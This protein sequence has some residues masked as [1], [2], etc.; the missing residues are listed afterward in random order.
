[1]ARF[2]VRRLIQAIPTLIGISIIAFAIMTLAPGGPTTALASDPNLTVQQREAIAIALGARDPIPTQYMRWLIGDAPIEWFGT[3]IWAGREVPT[4]DRLGNE[5][6]STS[7]TREGIL[8]GDW[9]TSITSKKPVLDVLGERIPATLELGIISLLVGTIVGIPIGVLSAVY[10][11]GLFDQVSRVG[12]VIVSAIPVFWLGLILLLI[13]GSW[14]GWFPMGNRFPLSFSGDYSFADRLRH[15]FLP[16][17]TL[18][19]F[20]IAT[21]SRYTR[22]SVLDVLGQDYIRTASAK[23][24]TGRTVWF[25]HGLRNALIP[26][27]TLL[28]PSITLTIGG[29]VLTETIYSWPGMGR[30][31]VNAVS[32]SDYPV[33]MASVMLLSVATIL[34]YIL[35]D[36]LYAVF[37]PRVRLS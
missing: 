24:L 10:R 13:F 29:A 2:L 26:I 17:F 21:F 11:G 6:G 14:L 16:V 9:G 31:V 34:G 12:A 33:I 37:D 4:F 18:S 1:M 36:I 32:Q 22:A 5:I 30:L 19:S 23:G 15:L 28:G 3:Q 27:A 25:K 35:S 7:G 8:R 20:S